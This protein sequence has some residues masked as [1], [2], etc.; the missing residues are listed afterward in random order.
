MK[1]VI[2]I[3]GQDRVGIVAR[4]STILAEHKINILDINQNI[5]NGF[6]NMVM[7]ADMKSASIQLKEFQQLLKDE[8]QNLGVDVKAQH[9]DIFNIMHRI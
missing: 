3:I 8:G 5:M 4:I 7:I 1:I 2:S 6:F 9:E